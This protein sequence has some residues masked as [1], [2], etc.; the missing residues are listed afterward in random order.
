MKRL[1]LILTL[2]VGSNI[3][4]VETAKSIG[5]A[6]GGS[7]SRQSSFGTRRSGESVSSTQRSS[8]STARSRLPMSSRRKNVAVP[9][10]MPQD[11]KR[12]KYKVFKDIIRKIYFDKS[13][14]E[15]KSI[16]KCRAAIWLY[17]QREKSQFL[18]DEVME[19]FMEMFLLDLAEGCQEFYD[20]VYITF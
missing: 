9:E 2:I 4:C 17:N 13:L 18:K 12:D 16:P 5:L 10:A 14:E 15:L 8:A 11:L 1:S 7:L 6:G 3:F 19:Q 20:E